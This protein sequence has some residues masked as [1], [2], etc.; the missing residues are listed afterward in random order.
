VA[1]SGPKLRW[2]IL[3][4][5]GAW[6]GLRWWT[7]RAANWFVFDD[8][9]YYFAI[10]RNLSRGLGSTFDG[11]HATNGYHPLWLALCTVPYLL[12]LDD[13]RAVQVLLSVCTLGL[14]AA[15]ALVVRV[16][17]RRAAGLAERTE[18]ATLAGGILVCAFAFSPLGVS[19]F[20]NGLEATC[21]LV[22]AAALIDRLDAHGDAL[23]F[24]GA[25][26][27]TRGRLWVSALVAGAF[28]SRTD[29]IFLLPWLGGWALVRS[30]GGAGERL[31]VV[32]ELCALPVAIVASYLALNRLAFGTATQVSG[33]LKRIAPSAEG[34]VTMVAL[35]ALPIV[36][37]LVL[38]K[39]PLELL[40]RTG[41]LLSSTAPVL[42]W[43]FSALAYYEGLQRWAQLWYFAVPCLYGALILAVA[44]VDLIDRARHERG[45][46]VLALV[47][48]VL[49]LAL[50]VGSVADAAIPG[51]FTMLET[52]AEAGR[53]AR[54]NV[55]EGAVLGSWDAGAIGYYSHGHVIN[56]DGEV[57][58]VSYLRAL[59]SGRTA[60]WAKGERIDYLVNHVSPD[61][62]EANGE[63]RF[64]SIAGSF[65]GE[66]RVAHWT[67]VRSWPF[68]HRGATNGRPR[69]RH[70]MAVWL[71]R[72]EGAK[73]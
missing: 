39:R 65:L 1:G 34:A 31:R 41:A 56:L 63:E 2:T 33:D 14:G 6:L 38:R 69:G 5:C 73:P 68:V 17:A 37:L 24:P 53:W 71:V 50:F 59:Q 4:L 70:P 18:L 19:I 11:L 7:P 54:A 15:V 49:P 9:F 57:N 22:F 46:K 72:L 21:T 35:V 51:A 43:A 13:E 20:A 10:A 47:L 67:L 40:A 58:D 42:L 36:V 66:E 30:R 62:N 29:A 55:P 3:V 52:D 61:A 27:N 60:E 44:L 25:S 12:G 23:Y 8:S 26:H 32:L 45:A 64:R 28:L 16:I 48:A